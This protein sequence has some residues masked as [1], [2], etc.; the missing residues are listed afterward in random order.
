VKVAITFVIVLFTWVFFRS[1]DLSTALS[2][3]ATML[4]LGPSQAGAG[5]VAGVIYQPYY[6]ATVLAAGTIV[7]AMPQTWDFTRRVTWPKVAATLGVLLIA[8]TALTTQTFNP[9]IYFIF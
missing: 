6:V 9:F 2:Y 5:L 8:I 3:C 7:W 4:G 1:P